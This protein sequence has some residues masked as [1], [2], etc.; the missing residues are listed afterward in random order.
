MGLDADDRHRRRGAP[1]IQGEYRVAPHNQ[2]GYCETV[3]PDQENFSS[4]SAH[5]PTLTPNLALTTWHSR[6]FQLYSVENP[7][8]PRQ[9]AEYLPQPLPVV[10]TEDPALSAGRDK[11]VMWSYPIVKDGLIYVIDLRNGLYILRYDGRCEEELNDV[12]FLEGN[13]NLGDALRF[14]RSATRNEYA[15]GCETPNGRPRGAELE[16]ETPGE[17]RSRGPARTPEAPSGFGSEKSLKR[18]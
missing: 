1:R 13:S 14:E 16:R 9:L 6:G 17:R 15:G 8:K 2:P 4:Q 12:S 11:V 10:Q 18:D 7:A 3:E 5:N